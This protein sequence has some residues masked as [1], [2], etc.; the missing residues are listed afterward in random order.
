VLCLEENKKVVI[1][2]IPGVGKT[3]VVTKVVEILKQKNISVT[4]V[5][6][7]TLMFEEA[8]KNSIKDRDEIRKL[9]ME[10]QQKFQKLAAERIAKL[11]DDV[12]IIDTHAFIST[13]SGFYPGMPDHVLQIIKPT[14]F[15]AVYAKPAIILNRRRE[16]DARQRDIVSIDTIKKE[17]AVQD[18]MLSC[19]SVISG[20]PM[21]PIL[22][23]EGKVDEAAMN[24]I[25]AIEV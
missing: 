5:S 18:A 10:Q 8:Q 14:N 4:V 22:N 1:V 12:V 3:T 21:K 13:P 20:S 24:V 16:D 19:C 7:G 9:T 23:D 25:I 2:G 15:I 6:F 17:L 11:S